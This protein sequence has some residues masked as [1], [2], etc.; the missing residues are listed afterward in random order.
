MKKVLFTTLS[1]IAAAA[2]VLVS[3]KKEPTEKPDDN[4]KPETPTEEVD[5]ELVGTWTITGKAQGWAADGGVAMT[6]SDNVWTA[7]EVAVKGEGFKFVKD[8]AW[9]INLGASPKTGATQKFDDDVEFDLEKD[10]DNIAGAK[11]GIYSV[12]LNL[13]TKKAK[14]KFVKD[15]EPETQPAIAVATWAAAEEAE[16]I[17]FFQYWTTGDWGNPTVPATEADSF[18]NVSFANGVYTYNITNGAPELWMAQLFLRP[19]PKKAYLPLAAGKF[20]RVS[21]TIESSAAM[22]PFV[23]FT[24][25][26]PKENEDHNSEAYKK[27]EG[28]CFVEWGDVKLEADAPHTFTTVIKV[29]DGMACNNVNWTLGLGGHAGATIKISNIIVEELTYTDLSAVNAL[30]ANANFELTAVVAESFKISDKNSAAIV[31]DGTNCFYLFFN[32]ASNNTYKAGDLV[33]AKGQISI[34]NKL[35]ESVKNPEV[36]VLAEGVAVPE[37][38]PVAI[39]SFDTFLAKNEPAGLYTASGKYVV[40]GSY[41][42]LVIDGSTAKGSLSGEIDSNLNGKNVTVTGWFTGANN[43]SSFA[44][45]RATKIEIAPVK[46]TI[47]GNMGEW[48][49]VDA[50]TS[51]GTSRI[52]SWKFASD[53][54]NLY[55]Y[56]V[57]RKNRM[58]TA[59][60]FTVGFSWDETGSLSGDNLSGLEAVVKFQPFTN[61]STGTPTCINGAID[62]ASIN[63]SDVTDAGIK[64]FGADPDSSATGDS[65]DYY[66]EVSIPKAKVPNLPASGALQIGVGYEWYKTDLQNVTL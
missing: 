14:I 31:T 8:G 25:Y 30:D 45:L 48:G 4:K 35:I 29:A 24:Q 22:T 19:N 47:D 11:D 50:L 5:P 46:I 28:G 52:R 20:Y 33:Y 32:P 1:I 64:A 66:L 15:L 37:L 44:Y 55:F 65:A 58:S 36:T 23:K 12:T 21:I 17:N 13:L 9:T 18:D 34:Y 38:T 43:S 53:A 27:H 10:G 7:A 61:A 3:C 60:P 39:E 59:Y 41:T 57:V 49:E 51:T 63:G 62:A 56:L 42:N 2:M 6:E 40:D 54:E 16:A 26:D